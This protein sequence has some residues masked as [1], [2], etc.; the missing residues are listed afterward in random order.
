MALT[1]QGV[2]GKTRQLTVP[3]ENDAKAIDCTD[4]FARSRAIYA[5]A[6]VRPDGVA[7][8][9]LPS[10]YPFDKQL[11][12]NPTQADLDAFVA[13]YQ[14]EIQKVFDTVKTAP[15]IVWDARNNTGGITTVG[16]AIVGGFPTARSTQ[17][18]YCRTRTAGSSPPAFD[19]E[20][21]AVY[22]VTPGGPFAYGGKVTVITDGLGYSAGDYFPRAV[23]K[24]SNVKVIGSASAGAYGGGS[25]PIELAG[26]PSLTAIA[27]PTACF[28][29]ATN[30]PL[31][32]APLPPTIA[33]ELD[34]KDLAAGKDTILERAVLE[35]GL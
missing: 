21:Y 20:R 4:T 35:L 28:D 16:L 10:F 9:R 19:T 13:A 12:Q 25:N 29:A 32:A 22:G 31:E 26:P 30:Q 23:A 8:I 27:D 5:E 34:P 14:A 7:V 1:V 6:K 2:D 33:V 15:G 18:S 17:L 24:A 3:A 11:P